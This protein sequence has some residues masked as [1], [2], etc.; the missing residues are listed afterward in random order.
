[1]MIYIYKLI[2]HVWKYYLIYIIIE[3]NDG[4]SHHQCLN[5]RINWACPLKPINPKLDS[6]INHYKTPTKGVYNKY[7]K[8]LLENDIIYDNSTITNL[9]DNYHNLIWNELFIV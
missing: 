6:R 4:I 8:A 1:M 3:L 7:R 9:Q 5:Y 2:M